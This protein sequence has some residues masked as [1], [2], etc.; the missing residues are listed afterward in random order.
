MTAFLEQHHDRYARDRLGHGIDA[1]D[2]I[3]LHRVPAPHVP[4]TPAFEVS[5]L[6][7][8]CNKAHRSR[9]AAAI[10]VRLHDRSDAVE[11][12]GREAHLFGRGL[13]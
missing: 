10:H 1:E 5:N 11:P 13:R 3:R 4:Q 2:G 6:A 9:D 12:L 7:T 8:A